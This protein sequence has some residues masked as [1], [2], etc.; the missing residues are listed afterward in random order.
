MFAKGI[1]VR[2]VIPVSL[3]RFADGVSIAKITQS[4]RR[5]EVY[6]FY[7]PPMCQPDLGQA[8][9]AKLLNATHF[10]SPRSIKLVLL[11]F[12]EGRADRKSEARVSA[13]VKELANV[14]EKYPSVDGVITFDLHAEQIV[15]AFN[16]VP[17]D[18]LKGR[19]ILARY[20]A[21]IPGWTP[22]TVGVVAPDVGSVKRNEK[23]AKRSGF[24]FKGL[25][26][27]ERS[28]PNV[29][30]AKRYIGDPVA[31]LHVIHADD[32]IDTASTIVSAGAKMMS[33]GALSVTACTTQWLASRKKVEGEPLLE[34]AEAKFRKAGIKVIALN[35]IPRKP[36]YLEENADF[37]T[38]IPCE[39]MLA[40][41]IVASLTAGSVSILSEEE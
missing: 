12:W 31:G 39:G 36:S 4:I 32:L 22:E 30:T 13:N 27:K 41:T 17:V 8:E 34:T 16:H 38:M 1:E 23:F 37:L 25:V 40:E 14:I 11:H 28:A 7:T 33:E 35:T 24:P 10:A 21:S 19:V 15:L 26:Y 6:L 2:P 29:A 5:T 18:D 9:L 20:A 3:N